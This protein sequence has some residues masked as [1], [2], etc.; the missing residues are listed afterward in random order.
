MI[1]RN[2]FVSD[3]ILSIGHNI[4]AVWSESNQNK[5]IIWRRREAKIT[6]AQWSST[7]PS[8]IFIARYDGMIELWDL[9]TRT[10]CPVIPYDGGAMVITVIT[11]HKLPLLNDVFLIG[12]VKSNLRLFIIPPVIS[13]PKEDNLEVTK[14]A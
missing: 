3:V 8:L 9:V 5:P 12:D 11:Q 1:E 14:S 2:P 10:D 7:N 4:F 13:K 6:C